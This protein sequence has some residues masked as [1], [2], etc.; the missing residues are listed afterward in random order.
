MDQIDS[1]GTNINHISTVPYNDKSNVK[2]R[3]KTGIEKIDQSTNSDLDHKMS[4]K[5]KNTALKQQRLP[6]WQPIL[7]AKTV[8]PLFFGIGVIF[9]TLGGVLLHF[10][11]LVQE[12][13]YDYTDCYSANDPS[14]KCSDISNLSNPC[15]CNI[16]ITLSADFQAPVYFYYGL[17]NFYQNHRRY[18][19]SR[20]DSQLLGITNIT[21]NTECQPYDYY[22]YT[23]GNTTY[24]NGSIYA[25]CGAIANS[26]F[27]DTFDL[28]YQASS[29]PVIATGIAWN[30]DKTVK[31]K[32][33]TGNNPWANTVKPLNWTKSVQ[34]LSTDSNNNGYINEDLIVWMR[35]AALPTFRKFYRRVNHT[36]AFQNNLPAGNYSLLISYSYP[37]TGFNGR[38]SFVISTTTWIGG[39]N[40]FLGIAYLVVGSLCIVLGIFFLIVHFKFARNL[41]ST[42]DLNR[43]SQGD[44]DQN[45]RM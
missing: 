36:G 3:S 20:D 21:L 43:N 40:P 13:T 39:K 44:N 15:T 12:F 24:K 6:A 30:T 33:P 11:D 32:N 37:V 45:I 7:T 41:P 29:V 4:K 31:F 25:P 2:N 1:V 16:P 17:K 5:P 42:D 26:L 19:K 38:K 27:T 18:V 9:V 10:S 23:S 28:Q 35:T 22:S 14:I 8:F 34:N